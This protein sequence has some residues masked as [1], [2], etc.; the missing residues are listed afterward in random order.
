MPE[1]IEIVGSYDSFEDF[2]RDY[3]KLKNVDKAMRPGFIVKN[4][5][6]EYTVYVYNWNEYNWDIIMNFTEE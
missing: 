2:C 6:D 1:N 5:L 3:D 4:S